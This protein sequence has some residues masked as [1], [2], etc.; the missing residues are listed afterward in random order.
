M[1]RRRGGLLAA[2]LLLSAVA[3]ASAAGNGTSAFNA[4]VGSMPTVAPVH[5][6]QSAMKLFYLD[7]FADT[8][9][10]YSDAVC[11]DGSTGAWRVR[12]SAAS[13]GPRGALVA[14]AARATA[15]ARGCARLLPR[16]WRG[17]AEAAPGACAPP[18]GAFYY[19]NA[20][21][22]AKAHIWLVYLEGGQ[23]CAPAAAKRS[24]LTRRSCARR[25]RPTNP[26]SF[27]SG[28][29]TRCRARSGARTCR[30]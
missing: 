4:Q 16:G 25:T 27:R 17:G 5:N 3:C 11:N 21:D 8:W 1:G 23:W 18:A 30:T 29:M 22:P 28:A 15:Y 12:R 7:D 6:G 14:R 19:A 20:T 9:A 24:A 26:H 13:R 2:A 10:S